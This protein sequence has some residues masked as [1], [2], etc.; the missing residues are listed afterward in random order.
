MNTHRREHHLGREWKGLLSIGQVITG[1][2][3]GELHASEGCYTIFGQP[4]AREGAPRKVQKFWR[5]V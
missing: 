3:C 1:T 5:N 2:A 4:V